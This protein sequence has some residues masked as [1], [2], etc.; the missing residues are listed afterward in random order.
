MNGIRVHHH[1]KPEWLASLPERDTPAESRVREMF[2]PGYERYVRLFHPFIPWGADPRDV[3]AH[4][5]RTWRQLAQQVGVDLH[6]A[7]QWDTLRPVLPVDG[8]RRPYE[9]HTGE[10]EPITRQGLFVHLRRHVTAQPTYFLY[11]LS[12]LI[13][14]RDPVTVEAEVDDFEKVFR[15]ASETNSAVVS[16]PEYIWPSDRAWIVCCDYDLSSTYVAGTSDLCADLLGDPSLEI[17]EVAL[18][19]RV[20]YKADADQ[21]LR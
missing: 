7:L 2:P 15:W 21:P 8:D 9:I 11:D 19:T 14:G 17:V 3:G 16:T 4:G 13:A 5:R 12:A 1:G 18:D 20:D 6:P 10:L